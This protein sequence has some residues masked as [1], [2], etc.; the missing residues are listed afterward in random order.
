MIKIYIDTNIFL[1]FYQSAT[2]RL[3]VFEEIEKHYK[4]I[5]LTEQTITEFR[6]N[7]NARLNELAK[8]INKS[9]AFN[10]YTTALVQSMPEFK[11][12][13]EVKDNAEKL[14]KKVSS[15]LLAW[16]KE[17]SSDPIH[18]AFEGLVSKS[19]IFPTTSESIEK[20][21]SRK[22][23]GNPPT[24]PDKHT[25]GDELIW[26]TILSHAKSDL[27]IVSRDK[28]FLENISLLRRE[29][30]A[31][32]SYK[33]IDVTP[34]LGDA[35]KA[36]GAPAKSV[37]KAEQEIGERKAEVRYPF[38]LTL[39]TKCPKCGGEL[40]ETGFEGSDGDSMWWVFCT[41]CRSDFFPDQFSK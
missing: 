27:I 22:L 1:D 38:P 29:Y 14:A 16:S 4:N 20:A 35:F 7:K 28:T 23:L 11:A 34:K 3:S 10:I 40:E 8:N 39:T 26:E 25:I 32:T 12:W 5:V 19:D 9:A 6:R 33:L 31:L 30:N 21:K 37:E 2:D 41:Q 17:E 15:Q 36:V 24:S 18:M 13:V